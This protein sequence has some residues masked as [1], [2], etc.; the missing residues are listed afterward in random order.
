MR[1]KLVCVP[2]GGGE[3]EYSLD[4]EMPALPR[5]G[6]YISVLRP[7]Q[8]GTEDFI[9]RRARWVFEFPKAP[10]V[11]VGHGPVGKTTEVCIEGEFAE[12][13]Y[14]SAEH[15]RTIANFA[16]RGRGKLEHEASGY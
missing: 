1:V 7:D 5:A 12:S 13:A 6:D 3:A 15:K 16:A 4:F 9:V 10:A 8:N 2:P 14:S 11:S